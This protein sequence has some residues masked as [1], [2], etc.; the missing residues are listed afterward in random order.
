MGI[1]MY[2]E[3]SQTQ[4]GHVITMCQA[5]LEAY[6]ICKQPFRPLHRT[7]RVYKVMLTTQLGT[8]SAVSCFP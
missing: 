1:D 8:F 3:Q 2:L 7:Q 4:S 6:Q 5:Q